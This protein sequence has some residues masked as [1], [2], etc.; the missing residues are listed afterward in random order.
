MRYENVSNKG[1]SILKTTKKST[2]K[3]FNNNNMIGQSDNNNVYKQNGEIIRD[4]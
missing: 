3:I 4:E 1:S 2:V